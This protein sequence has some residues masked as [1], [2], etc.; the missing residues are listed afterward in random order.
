MALRLEPVGSLQIDTLVNGPLETNTY[1]AVSGDELLVIDPAWDGERLARRIEA[2][3][4]GVRPVGIVCTHGHADHVG[5]VAGLRRALGKD[6]PFALSADDAGSIA[7]N[8]AYQREKWGFEADDPGAPDRLLAE[9]DELRVGD[10]TLQVIAVPGH[11]PG[12]I[13]LFCAASE[14]NVA[15]VG[16]TLFPG[17]HGRTDLEG[18]DDVAIMQSLAKL[19]RLLPADTVCLTGHGPATTIEREL[20]SNPF[21][22]IALRDSDQS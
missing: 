1:V 15:F 10:A 11:T 16:D 20:A 5:G 14:G 22:I 19:G 2:A 21:M 13:V 9:G 8:I 6:I 12:G 3:H 18:G 7:V 17:S 4:P